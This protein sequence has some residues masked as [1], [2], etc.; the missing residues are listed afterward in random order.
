MSAGLYDDLV[1]APVVPGNLAQAN[2]ANPYADLAEPVPAPKKAAPPVTAADRIQAAEGGIFKG[3]AYLAGLVPDAL[4]NVVNLG[5]AA[6]GYVASKVN[7]GHIPDWADPDQGGAWAPSM[8]PN[9][10]GGALVKALDKSPITT[11]QPNRPDDT[12]SRYLNTAGSVVP[13]VLTGSEGSIPAT[14]KGLAAAVPSAAAGQYV[15][16]AK[17]FESDAA[18]TAASTL[19]QALTTAAI[20]RGRVAAN[21]PMTDTVKAAQEAD[22]QFPPATTNPTAVNRGLESVAGKVS[23]QQ[24]AAINN[25]EVTNNQGRAAMG[26]PAGKGP[27][28]EAEIAD[29]KTAAAPGYD[30]LRAAG[31]IT[32]PPTFAKSLDAA[33]SRMSGAS[34]L[35]PSLKN[36]QLESLVSEL[37]KN[38]SFDAGDAMDTIAELRDK[39]S[40][41]YRQGDASAG[42]AYRNVSGVLED[43]IHSDLAK[44]GQGDLV[45]NFQNSRQQFARIATVEEN[46]NA[47]TGNLQAQKL[48][49]ALKR[50]DY[51]GP[52][53]DPLKVTAQAAG[54]APRAFVEPTSS[55]AS[56][57]GVTEMLAGALLGGGMGHEGGHAGLGA[58]ALA[59]GI[60]AARYG[61]RVAALTW[62]GQS[63]VL[64][65]TR[66]PLPASRLAGAL[67]S[68]PLLAVQ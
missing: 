57:L 4:A 59:A 55:P 50:G 53:G 67:T 46:L 41:A 17:P 58:A 42:K 43:A 24:H 62:P 65:T 9:P 33:I 60:P 5:R 61:A 49:S 22:F 37:K 36:T 20:P 40:Q 48:A 21:T 28:T 54:V 12:A 66:A 1:A 32:A 13:G 51:L 14:L 68:N 27:I 7:G 18:N 3:G 6:G 56:H 16:E 64:P 35:A 25:Q 30:A 2:Q 52:D 19:A 8:E 15:A 31:T 11:T 23:V 63:N 47:T 45:A 44:R 10:V 38:G 26:V 29:A 39:A 34:K